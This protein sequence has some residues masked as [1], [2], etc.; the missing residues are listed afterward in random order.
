[1]HIDPAHMH[2]HEDAW[3][4]LVSEDLLT[5]FS[6]SELTLLARLNHR[7]LGMYLNCWRAMW[8]TRSQLSTDEEFAHILQLVIYNIRQSTSS[9]FCGLSQSRLTRAGSCKRN[10][11]SASTS[12]RTFAVDAGDAEVVQMLLD[13]C[14]CELTMMSR[15]DGSSCLFASAEFASVEAPYMEIVDTVLVRGP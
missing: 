8:R 1:L 10:S 4:A 9:R 12:S 5:T 7:F 2:P 14:G 13:V 6:F 11:R 3:R 15:V